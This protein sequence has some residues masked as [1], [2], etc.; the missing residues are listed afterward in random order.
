MKLVPE[1]Q[2][3]GTNDPKFV[4]EVINWGMIPKVK[5]MPKAQPRDINAR[6]VFSLSMTVG[7]KHILIARSVAE[8]PIFLILISKPEIR[9]KS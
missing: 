7:R 6:G 3:R 2:L 1:V 4:L 8:G 9:Y 5:L